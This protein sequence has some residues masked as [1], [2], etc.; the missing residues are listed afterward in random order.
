MHSHFM[1]HNVPTTS[2]QTATN[3]TTEL[4]SFERTIIGHVLM[5][6]LLDVF[7]H[8]G[9]SLIAARATLCDEHTTTR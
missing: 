8:A 3:V 9:V 7:F 1:R 4:R 6:E 2:E 5:E